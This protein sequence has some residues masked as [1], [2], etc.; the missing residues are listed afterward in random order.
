MARGLLP[1][2]HVLMTYM[3]MCKYWARSGQQTSFPQKFQVVQVPE[4]PFLFP[5]VPFS[6]VFHYVTGE[7]ELWAEFPFKWGFYSQ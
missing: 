4:N 7:L 5:N 3:E 6:R 1:R 2:P